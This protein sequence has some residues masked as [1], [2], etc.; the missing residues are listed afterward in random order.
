MSEILTCLGCGAT[1][2]GPTGTPTDIYPSEHCGE[3]PPWRCGDCG[4]MS[5]ASNLCSCW[6]S[7][8]GMALADIKAVFAADGTFS[9]GGLASDAANPEENL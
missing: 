3:C 8:D 9:L 2:P 6:Q 4:E 7:F 1:K 5:S